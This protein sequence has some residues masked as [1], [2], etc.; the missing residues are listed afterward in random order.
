MVDKAVLVEVD[1]DNIAWG[2]LNIHTNYN[3][4]SV[5]RVVDG[6]REN[7]WQA[8]QYPAEN[9]KASSVR[10]LMEYHSQNEKAVL[11]EIRIL[12]TKS[13]EAKKPEFQAPQNYAD[14]SYANMQIIEA[15]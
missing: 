6:N 14:S 9:V 13:G 2:S 5:E 10:I 7:S 1:R 12:G 11:N 15:D 4:E 3:A 8:F